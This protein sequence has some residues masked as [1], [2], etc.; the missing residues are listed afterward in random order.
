M[1]KILSRFKEPSSWAGL[2]AIA[3]MFGARPDQVDAVHGV[4]TAVATA[5]GGTNAAVLTQVVVAVCGAAAVFL[6]EKK[7]NP[8]PAA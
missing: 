2:A 1:L 5:A 4:V 7:A 3:L 6:P 8:A